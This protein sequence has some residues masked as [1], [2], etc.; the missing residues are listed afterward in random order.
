MKLSHDYF[1]RYNT[2]TIQHKQSTGLFMLNGEP[3][4]RD[5]IE[6]ESRQKELLQKTKHTI[7]LYPS[8]LI[9][10]PE[11]GIES[12]YK[13]HQSVD[14]SNNRSMSPRRRDY[15]QIANSLPLNTHTTLRN[16][17]YSPPRAVLNEVARLEAVRT[18]TP[19]HEHL[20]TERV[21][22]PHNHYSR[23]KTPG[24]EVAKDHAKAHHDA[25]I[26]FYKH[27][28][29]DDNFK[30]IHEEN[31]IIHTAERLF[32][33]TETK[34]R[35]L[36]SAWSKAV[37]TKAPNNKVALGLTPLRMNG[38]G[39]DKPHYVSKERSIET[40]NTSHVERGK[41]IKL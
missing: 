1:H 35:E 40:M 10:Y 25:R 2:R 8:E 16:G 41:G 23:L 13:R 14:I 36:Q 6:D 27:I 26:Q 29:H 4:P 37:P 3:L 21:R 12:P 33:P 39:Q 5:V 19:L 11:D 31:K 15:S 30:Q 17:A 20:R 9:Y 28:Y 7:R 22:L 18:S 38:H 32:N 34:L 24:L